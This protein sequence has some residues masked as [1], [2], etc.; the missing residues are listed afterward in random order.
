MLNF[1]DI[2][3]LVARLMISAVFVASAIDKFRLIPAELEQIASL[4][5]PAPAIVARLTGIFEVLGVASL[6][7]GFYTRTYA[8]ILAIF[9]AFVTLAFVKFWSFDGP[10]ELK[11]MLRNIFFGNIA[12]TGGLIYL[13][14]QGPGRLAVSA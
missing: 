5:L 2:A 11:G 10:L 3:L 13:A 8:L 14:V 7:L 9:M 1:Q 4:H 12:I 6:V